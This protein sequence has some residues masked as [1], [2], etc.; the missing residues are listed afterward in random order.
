MSGRPARSGS[1]RRSALLLTVATVL[2]LW[3]GV[4]APEVSPVTGPPAPVAASQPAVVPAASDAQPDPARRAPGGERCPPRSGRM[5]APL[6]RR[7]ALATRP[8]RREADAPP[9]W[10]T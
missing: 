10:S 1:P 4:S 9:P 3:F 6:P 2:G 5:A 7:S 8:R